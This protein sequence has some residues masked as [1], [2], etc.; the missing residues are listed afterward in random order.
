MMRMKDE[1]LRILK[2]KGEDRHGPIVYWMSRD[3]RAHDNWALLF[4]QEMALKQKTSLGIVFCLGPKFLGATIR[5]YGFML[6]GL[7]ETEKNLKAGNIPLKSPFWLKKCAE[8][9]AF[10]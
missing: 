3:Q 9:N 4:A 1:R 2:K 8:S 7:Q 5:Q 6:K 10:S